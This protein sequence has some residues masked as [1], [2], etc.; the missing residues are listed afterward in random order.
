MSEMKS[1]RLVQRLK[2]P[3]PGFA[4]AKD[5]PFSFGGGYKNGGLSPEAMDLLRPNFSFEYMGA[6]EFE[7]GAVP[8]ALALI[9]A[10]SDSLVAFSFRFPQAEVARHWRDKSNTLP[11]G[12]VEIFVICDE[13]WID[14]VTAR[15]RLWASQDSNTGR[16]GTLHEE[17]Q[18]S[19]VLRPYGEGPDT[20]G[21]L[22]LNNGFFF[23]TDEEM[24]KA[25]AELFDVKG[26]TQ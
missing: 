26:V 11:T 18:L 2:K 13:E 21:W 4:G 23:F 10:N 17:S 24:W 19:T 6:A 20:C 12:T 3:F 15:I 14:Q 25:T 7:F 9:H 8:K 16:G 5:N 1:S 22:E